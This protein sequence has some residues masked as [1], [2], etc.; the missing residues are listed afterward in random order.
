MDVRRAKW[1][2]TWKGGVELQLY[3]FQLAQSKQRISG[4][5]KIPQQLCNHMTTS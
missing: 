3:E 5:K 2:V 1:F 4:K